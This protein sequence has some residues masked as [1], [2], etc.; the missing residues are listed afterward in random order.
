MADL[1]GPVEIHLT[2][3]QGS[4]LRVEGKSDMQVTDGDSNTALFAESLIGGSERLQ[5]VW[6]LPGEKYGVDEFAAMVEAC[7]QIPEDPTSQGWIGNIGGKGAVFQSNNG[8][9]AMVIGLSKTMYNH[10]MTRKIRPVSTAKL[11]QRHL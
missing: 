11:L 9:S 10:A 3:Y 8:S 7:K 4:T 1:V 5:G 2:P 6:N